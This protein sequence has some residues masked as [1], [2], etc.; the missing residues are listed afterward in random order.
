MYRVVVHLNDG[1]AIPGDWEFAT[2]EDIEA[3]KRFFGDILG[4]SGGWQVNLVYG[5][6]WGIFPKDSVKYIEIQNKGDFE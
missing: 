6:S 5:N 4:G 3:S 2:E 1:R